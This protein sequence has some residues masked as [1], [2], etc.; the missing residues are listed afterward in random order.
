MD[1]VNKILLLAVISA[2]LSSSLLMVQSASAQ[3][4]PKPSVPEF[5]LRFVDNS[6]DVEPRYSYDSYTGKNVLAENGYHV[7]NKTIELRI[8]NQQFTSYHD[9]EGNLIGLYYLVQTKGYFGGSW[10]YIDTGYYGPDNHYVGA[11]PEEDYTLLVY[12]LVGNNGTLGLLNLDISGGG[13]A[14]FRVQAFIGYNN[15][16]DDGYIMG[17]KSSHYVFTGQQSEWSNPQT[18]SLSDISNPQ[19]TDLALVAAVAVLGVAVVSLLVYVRKI[20]N[21]LPK[22]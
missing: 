13:K 7:Q 14:D 5:T 11:V 21:R 1:K 4:T 22:Q 10:W 2:L 16:I 18:I 9:S 20:K 8:K 3:S 6:Y 15:Q 17:Y 19:L 12:G